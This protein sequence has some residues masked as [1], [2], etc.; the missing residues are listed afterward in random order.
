[1]LDQELRTLLLVDPLH[2]C[3]VHGIA[4]PDGIQLLITTA[5]RPSLLRQIPTALPNV[6]FAKTGDLSRLHEPIIYNR[7]TE[8]L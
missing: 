2:A 1:M 8:S 4:S 3:K 6:S 5:D 7:K